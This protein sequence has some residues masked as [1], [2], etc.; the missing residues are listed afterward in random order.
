MNKIQKVAVCSRSFSANLDLRAELLLNYS[1]VT[2]ND[3]GLKLDGKNLVEFLRGHEKAIIGLEKITEQ[4]LS[5]LPDLKVIAKFGVGL[6]SIDLKSMNKFGV[7]LG[8]TPGTNKRSVSELV[9]ALIISTLRNLPT[10]NMTTRSGLWHQSIGGL[11]SGRTVGIVGCNNIGKDL[12]T[13]LKPWDCKFLVHD[14]VDSREFNLNYEVSFVGLE[15]LLINSDIISL[16]LPLNSSTQN[17]ISESRIKLMKSSAIL[18]NTARGGLVDESALKVALETNQ[19][20]GAAF[21]VFNS[22]PPQDKNLLNLSNFI[23][24]PHIGGSTTEATLAMGRAAIR[25]LD[26]NTIPT[27]SS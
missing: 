21:D 26:E 3:K 6:D 5:Q 16:H 24:T 15:E 13:I 17:I 9:V 11:L 19:I 7:R 25:G 14:I 4:V 23:A 8:W 2:F 22:E 12:I 18:I 20:A 10:L 1:K 27:F